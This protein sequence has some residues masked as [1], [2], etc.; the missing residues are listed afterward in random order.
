MGNKKMADTGTKLAPNHTTS[1]TT[2]TTYDGRTEV[3]VQELLK[4]PNVKQII[5]EISKTKLVPDP[6]E[7]T[8]TKE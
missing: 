7:K 8:S 6:L 1:T 2:N 3:N 5:E 4:R